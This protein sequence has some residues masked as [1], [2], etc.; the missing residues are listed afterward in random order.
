MEDKSIPDAQV[1]IQDGSKGRLDN[2]VVGTAPGFMRG[3]TSAVRALGICRVLVAV[4][5]G[6]ANIGVT[7]LRQSWTFARSIGLAVELRRVPLPLPA[8]LAP[9][10]I[11]Q[12]MFR[13]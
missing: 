8:T 11:A 6:S 12:I 3:N 5:W 4:M 9:H 1:V 2:Y 7:S 13:Q 10:G